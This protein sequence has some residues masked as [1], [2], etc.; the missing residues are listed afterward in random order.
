[1]KSEAS[2]GR[3][4]PCGL[5]DQALTDFQRTA[6]HAYFVPSCIAPLKQSLSHS[7][8]HSMTAR[9]A[10]EAP[11]HPGLLFP[12]QAVHP[13]RAAEGDQTF[14]PRRSGAFPELWGCSG[15]PANFA[16]LPRTLCKLPG[17]RKAHLRQPCSAQGAHHPRGQR[18]RAALRS[19]ELRVAGGPLLP[20][21]PSS[22]PEAVAPP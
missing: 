19:E 6:Q 16:L 2:G 15:D 11:A 14:F 17:Q 9:P 22:T 21:P 20:A 10:G 18:C 3:T 5:Q 1:M 8:P 12:T 13:C 4:P 7:S